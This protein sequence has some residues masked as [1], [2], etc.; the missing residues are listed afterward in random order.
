MPKMQFSPVK[1]DFESFACVLECMLTLAN[2]Q[3]IS[4]LMRK[5]S[6]SEA[7]NFESYSSFS[8]A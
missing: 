7:G 4:T 2:M 5:K 8:Y 6:K 1:E 3:N